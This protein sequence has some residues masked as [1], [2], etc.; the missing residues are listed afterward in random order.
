MIFSHHGVKVL[1]VLPVLGQHARCAGRD[2]TLK[3][4]DSCMSSRQDRGAIQPNASR[5]MLQGIVTL[6]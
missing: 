5:S 4:P 3:C 1:L 2:P 6:D